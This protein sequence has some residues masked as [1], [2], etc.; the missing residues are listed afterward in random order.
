MLIAAP[1]VHARAAAVLLGVAREAGLETVGLVDAGLAAA[2]LEP[3]PE[4]VLQLEL[5]LHRAVLTVLDHG[6]ELRRTRY[7]LLPQ[8][9]WLALQQAW[10]DRI[11]AAFVRKTR[12]DPLH[13]AANEQ[14]LWDGLPGWLGCSSA[15]TGRASRSP[16]GGAMHAVELAREEF[17]AAAARIYDGLTRCS[18]PGRARAAAPAAVA[19]LGGLPGFAE[20]LAGMRDC[21]VTRLPRGAAALGALAYERVL[22]RDPSVHWCWCSG[23]PCRCERDAHRRP[24]AAAGAGRGASDPRRAARSCVDPPA[25]H[26]RSGPRCRPDGE[27]CRRA[28][29]RHLPQPLHARER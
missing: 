13:E 23:C 24:A 22:R 19:A 17:V 21:E 8:H 25:S 20:R 15:S 27:R 3:A 11:A 6:G 16:A 14:R 4:A 9:G 29:A 28:R 2:S 18:G 12:F 1:L 5:A 26:S 7:E 10:L